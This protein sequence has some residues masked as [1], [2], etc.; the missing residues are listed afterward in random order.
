MLRR[1]LIN[2]TILVIAV[3]VGSGLIEAGVRVLYPQF[4]P[5]GHLKLRTNDQGVPLIVGPGIY[6]QVKNTGDFDVEV[7]VNDLG[8]REEKPLSASTPKDLFVV[9][10]SF[11]LGWGVAV[12]D[13]FSNVLE[14]ALKG[15]QVFNISVPTGFDGYASLIDYAKHHGAKVSRLIVGVT[16]ENDLMD[17]RARGLTKLPEGHRSSPGGSRLVAVKNLLTQHSAA[18]FM[19]TTVFHATPVLKKA[20]V[21]IGLIVPNLEAPH[22]FNLVPRVV[23]P[24]VQRL[25]E[26]TRGYG[27][28]TILIVPS[29]ALWVG[30]AEQRERAAQIHTDF[31]SHLR[32][33]GMRVVDPRSRMEVSG[34]PLQF[35][36]ANDGHWNK[37]GHALAAKMLVNELEKRQTR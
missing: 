4:D 9:G 16:M 31:V 37:K 20:A 12:E 15:P 8:F 23:D 27:D 28:V 30:T 32:K 19:L 2:L 7:A 22:L 26:I 10:D 34:N 5:S 24:S 14:R 1:G 29:R 11:A 13:R 35:H 17:Y 36:F 21:E 33:L 25:Y 3:V 18:Y 6:R